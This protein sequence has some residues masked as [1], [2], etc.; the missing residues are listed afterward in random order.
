MEGIEPWW[1]GTVKLLQS[2]GGKP[3]LFG[4]LENG[5]EELLEEGVDIDLKGR[6]RRTAFAEAHL[7]GHFAVEAFLV[8][9]GCSR[10]IPHP[11]H[12]KF[13]PGGAAIPRGGVVPKREKQYS[14]ASCLP[15][16]IDIGQRKYL[17]NVNGESY[18]IGMW[19]GDWDASFLTTHLL[20]IIIED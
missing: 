5:R 1:Q 11:E 14:R 17:T 2:E 8:Q 16:A 12:L 9:Q 19:I 18:P 10:E 3:G 7:R 20:K 6:Y 13:N 4:H 15:E